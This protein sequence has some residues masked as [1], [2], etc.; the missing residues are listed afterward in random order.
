VSELSIEEISH[1]IIRLVEQRT[2]EAK[3]KAS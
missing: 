3:A 2:A 1:R